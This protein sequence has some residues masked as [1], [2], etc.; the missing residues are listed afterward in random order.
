MKV[1]EALMPESVH[2]FYCG[3][4][5]KGAG[6]FAL[7]N[8]QSGAN[9]PKADCPAGWAFDKSVNAVEGEI[10][11][12]PVDAKAALADLENTGYHLMYV[13]GPDASAGT[14]ERSA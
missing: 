3:S 4:G 2:L 14:D 11:G 8:D 1:K 5:F 6:L 7:S 13:K 12:I 10:G 9:L